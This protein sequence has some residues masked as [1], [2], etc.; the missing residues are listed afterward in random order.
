MPDTFVHLDSI[1]GLPQDD[2]VTNSS[3]NNI[4]TNNV[5]IDTASISNTHPTAVANTASAK[6]EPHYLIFELGYTG[7]Y[8]HYIRHL[9]QFWS[10]QSYP[11]RLTV[12]VSPQFAQLHSDV[13]KVGEQVQP[14]RLQ[15]KVLPTD[16]ANRLIPR[17]SPVKRARRSLQE[18]SLLQR[19]VQQLQITHCLL[20][21]FDSFQAAALLRRPISCLVSGIYFRPTLHYRN[22]DHYCSSFKTTLQEWRER[23]VLPQVLR[24]PQLSH[25][26]CLDPFFVDFA[27]TQL[28]LSSPMYLSDPVEIAP[29]K[30]A[31]QVLAFKQSLGIEDNRSTFLLFGALYDRRKGIEQVLEAIAQ[32][33]PTICQQICLL[34]VGQLNKDSPLLET[35]Q[36]L[37]QSHLVQI[38]IRDGFVPDDEVSLCFECADVVLAPYQRHVG[39]SGILVHAAAAQKP[40]IASNYG[41]LG[42]LVKQHQ[43]GITVDSASPADIAKAIARCLSQSENEELGDRSQMKAFAQQ[44]SAKN[45]ATTIFQ[46]LQNQTLQNSPPDTLGASKTQSSMANSS[47]H[48]SVEHYP[49][50]SSTPKIAPK[51]AWL[52]QGAGA[53]WQPILSEF[54]QVLPN[55]KVFTADWPGFMPGFEETF[56]VQQV[57]PMK[58]LQL[59]GKSGGY[60]RCVAYLPPEVIKPVIDYRPELVFST[61]FSL[62][63]MLLALLKPI[64]R[65]RLVIVYDGSSPGVDYENSWVRSRQRRWLAH[66]ADAFITNNK[67]GK[68]YIVNSLKFPADRVFDRPYLL[69]HPKTYTRSLEIAKP[70]LEKQLEKQQRPVFV[71]AGNLIPR[72][73]LQEL[74]HACT[75]LKQQGHEQFTLVVV[76]D[77]SERSALEAYVKE[78]DLSDQ[79]VWIGAVEY[80]QVGAYF[81]AAD[82]FIFP[83]REDVWGLVLVEAMM[84]GKPV[85][86]SKW[87]GASEMVAE[88]ENGYIFDPYAPQQLAEL[89]AKFI[90]TPA[91]IEQ[92]GEASR[93][94][95]KD[96]Q[97]ETVARS[98]TEVVD[99]V[100]QQK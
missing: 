2:T 95:M 6:A 70:L 15:F 7:H 98:L 83:T 87:A 82:V 78:Q 96:H 36:Q 76:G 84:F 14:S 21:Y 42:E 11:G 9:A 94:I 47:A 5:T 50:V 32:S 39:M 38:I 93:H 12:V 10:E 99:F 51:V 23:L 17:Q 79:I 43:L 57:G 31:A 46:A 19:Y 59:P 92:M 88:G 34:L 3:I 37:R 1:N 86:A 35:I 27:H 90:D 97:L 26:F 89:M 73:G 62:W 33:H 49:V 72:K 4:T 55:T 44:N 13:L 58:L 54:T 100:L 28:R 69:P 30:S 91:L 67:A 66:S 25:L 61:G 68:Q 60:G 75:L 40:L 65:W 22:F 45:F 41:L 85:L 74:L 64:F 18:W 29:A 24:H 80:E 53:Y 48:S 71:F 52:L 63:T 81:E 8:P 16:E 20:L 56:E 77:G